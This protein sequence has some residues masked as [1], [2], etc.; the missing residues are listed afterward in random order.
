MIDLGHILLAAALVVATAADVIALHR[1][2]TEVAALRALVVDRPDTAAPP[3]PV[4]AG[5]HVLRDEHE[6]PPAPQ[7][8]AH[9]LRDERE[10][11]AP[12]PMVGPDTLRTWIK[13][14]HP[15]R[16]DAWPLVV[17]EFYKRAAADPDVADYFRGV[18][19]D[20]LQQHFMR[21]LIL[22]S[23]TGVTRGTVN[24]MKDRHA[25]VTNSA[26]EPITAGIYDRVIGVL[27][28]VLREANV[29]ASALAGL[30]PIADAFRPALVRPAV[31]TPY[32]RGRG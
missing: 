3:A 22:V 26:G 15:Y 23:H 10:L 24:A 28:D 8:P 30:V 31:P 11:L 20:V 4:E 9:F 19:L 5:R 21:A 27:V 7:P 14:H 13:E 16:D 12:P 25:A 17:A 6:Q 32:P 18:D 1:Y 29:P 2:R